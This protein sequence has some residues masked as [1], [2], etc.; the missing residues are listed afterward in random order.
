[1][2]HTFRLA[3]ANPDRAHTGRGGFDAADGCGGIP[4]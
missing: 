1:M 2:T 4:E 3:R